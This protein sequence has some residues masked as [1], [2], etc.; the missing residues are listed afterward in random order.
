MV[1]ALIASRLAQSSSRGI[2]QVRTEGK[3][4]SKE[5][6]ESATAEDYN[7]CMERHGASPVKFMN[8]VQETNIV[9]AEQCSRRDKQGLAA[10]YRIGI[11]TVENWL[12]TGIIAGRRKGRK[13][14][15]CAHTL[16][17]VCLAPP[18]KQ[19]LLGLCQ[20]RKIHPHQ[21]RRRNVENK[22][23]NLS[24]ILEIFQLEYF[25]LVLLARKTIFCVHLPEDEWTSRDMRYPPENM[26]LSDCD[27]ETCARMQVHQK[28]SIWEEIYVFRDVQTNV[29]PNVA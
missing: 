17:D 29:R 13:C 19:P 26:I 7:G 10:H 16:W 23:Q 12:S 5:N 27:L 14:P 24:T 2:G 9:R 18:R 20:L 6:Y 21:M 4:F 11:R 25:G 15:F 1:F 8:T 3:M 22:C 28:L